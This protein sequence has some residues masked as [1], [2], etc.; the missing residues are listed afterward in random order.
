MA[1]PPVRGGVHGRCPRCRT[2]HALLPDCVHARRLDVV[3]VIWAALELGIAGRDAERGLLVRELA[4][5][6]RELPD[7]S[8]GGVQP[9]DARPLGPRLPGG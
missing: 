7:G 8:P 3:E 6:V 5:Q 4:A 1:M 2:T 9:G